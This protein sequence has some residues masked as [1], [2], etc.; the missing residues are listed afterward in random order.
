MESLQNWSWQTTRKV[1]RGNG[2]WVPDKWLRA[3]VDASLQ[4][5]E[6]QLQK[7]N[8]STKAYN[9]SWRRSL[10]EQKE[11]NAWK[12]ENPNSKVSYEYSTVLK[13]WIFVPK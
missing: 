1:E 13:A 11:I 9:E 3:V 4:K 2:D 12:K 6:R 5:E 8:K 10:Q 7:T